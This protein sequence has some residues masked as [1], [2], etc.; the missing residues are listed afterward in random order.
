MT[1][2][3]FAKRLV[4][5]VSD[6]DL[7]LGRTVAASWNPMAGCRLTGPNGLETL[8]AQ[9]VLLAMGARET[10]RSARLISGTRPWAS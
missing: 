10:P 3:D 4:D 8:Q 1:G 9:K 5:R 7:R 2:P 6:L